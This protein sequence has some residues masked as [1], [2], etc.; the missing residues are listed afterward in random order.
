MAGMPIVGIGGPGG[1]RETAMLLLIC[2]F[3][4]FSLM[5]QRIKDLVKLLENFANG[6]HE[7]IQV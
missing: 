5:F 1:G 4:Y 6:F 3:F 2:N 7:L